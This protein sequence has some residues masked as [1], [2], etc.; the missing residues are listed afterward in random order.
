[1]LNEGATLG[2][3]ELTGYLAERKVAK[4]MWPEQLEIVTDMP[5][6]PTRKV[7]KSELVRRLLAQTDMQGRPAA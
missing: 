6:T 5:M 2:F 1:M 3:E 4:F 7:I